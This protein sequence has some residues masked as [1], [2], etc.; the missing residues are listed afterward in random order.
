MFTLLVRFLPSALVS[1]GLAVG[2][3]GL[4]V[5]A[6]ITIHCMHMLVIIISSIIITSIIIITNIIISIISIISIILE[7]V[8]VK[9]APCRTET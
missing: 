2:T 1:A 4:S 3:A 9:A 8:V 7:T 6:I 5:V